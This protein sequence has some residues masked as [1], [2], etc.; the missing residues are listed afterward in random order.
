MRLPYQANA[1][2]RGVS[3]SRMANSVEPSGCPLPKKI[4]CAGAIAA[5]GAVCYASLGTACVQCLA[6]IGASGCLDCF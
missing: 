4:A 6:G 5:C 3:I 2:A 1:V